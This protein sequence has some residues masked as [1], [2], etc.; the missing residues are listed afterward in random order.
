MVDSDTKDGPRLTPETS[1]TR[2]PPRPPLRVGLAME[3]GDTRWPSVAM[4]H[5]IAEALRKHWAEFERG[6]NDGFEV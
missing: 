4:T 6:G 3:D 1:G 5:K 2:K